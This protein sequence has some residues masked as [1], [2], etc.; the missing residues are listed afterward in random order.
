M[1]KEKGT[2]K[3]LRNVQ[4][5]SADF[6]L[7]RPIENNATTMQRN[8][9]AHTARR[10]SKLSSIMH[11]LSDHTARC[12]HL[13]PVIQRVDNGLQWINRY[14]ADNCQQ[15]VLGYPP[16]RDLFSGYRYPTL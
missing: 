11:K 3:L 14:P 15:N 8:R 10:R 12:K 2:T 4:S 5:K 1:V 7:H 13:S 9:R 6:R 16:D